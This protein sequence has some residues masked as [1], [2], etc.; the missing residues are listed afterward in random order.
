LPYLGATVESFEQQYQTLNT[1]TNTLRASYEEQVRILEVAW[2][3]QLTVVTN[4]VTA[5]NTARENA[6]TTMGNNYNSLPSNDAL[7]CFDASIDANLEG[8]LL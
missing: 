8:K 6:T 5:A 3:N 7:A 4:S 1:A 2:Q